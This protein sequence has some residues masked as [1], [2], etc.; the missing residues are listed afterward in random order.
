MCHSPTGCISLASWGGLLARGRAN[1]KIEVQFLGRSFQSTETACT[2]TPWPRGSSGKLLLAPTSVKKGKTE[3]GG[4]INFF[5]PQKEYA[6]FSHNPS[7]KDQ[8][9]FTLQFPKGPRLAPRPPTHPSG[10]ATP[11]GCPHL[12]PGNTLAGKQVTPIPGA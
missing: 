7:L 5:Q 9:Y 4:T 1:G 8:V 6:C 11:P 2:T 12:H 10:R 3:S